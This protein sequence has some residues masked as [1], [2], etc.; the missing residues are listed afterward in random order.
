MLKQM[1][2][3]KFVDDDRKIGDVIIDD[4]STDQTIKALMPREPLYKPVIERIFSNKGRKKGMQAMR[5]TPKKK[6]KSIAELNELKNTKMLSELL[7]VTD[8]RTMSILFRNIETIPDLL[9]AVDRVV[10]NPETKE[11]CRSMLITALGR[12]DV[13]YFAQDKIFVKINVDDCVLFV[14]TTPR[15]LVFVTKSNPNQIVIA[16]YIGSVSHVEIDPKIWESNSEDVVDIYWSLCGR[17]I[18]LST[19]TGHEYTFDT[20]LGKIIENKTKSSHEDKFGSNTAKMLYT[21]M[22]MKTTEIP[23]LR[24]SMNERYWFKDTQI[25]HVGIGFASKELQ[26]HQKFKIIMGLN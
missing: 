17:Y 25:S 21:K 5:A 11:H 2:L 6:F 7:Y 8:T 15:A 23:S 14:E 4:V 22:F 16:N 18:F 24:L 26:N 20:F 1:C 9:K 13:P 10:I 12:L 3:K 19:N